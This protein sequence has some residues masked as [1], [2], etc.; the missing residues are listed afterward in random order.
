MKSSVSIYLEYIYICSSEHYKK[1]VILPD[2]RKIQSSH[3]VK[4]LYKGIKFIRFLRQ[5]KLLIVSNVFRILSA[6]K[7]FFHS[8]TCRFPL[9]KFGDEFYHVFFGYYDMSPFSNDNSR[10][11]A[12]RIPKEKLAASSKFPLEIGFY[13]LQAADL[14][15]KRIGETSTWCS[16]QGCRL[17]WYPSSSNRRILYNCI[18]EEAYGCAI[19]DIETGEVLRSIRRPVYTV[20]Q[21]GRWGL[22]L[23][24]S[25]LN[26]LRPGYGYSNFASCAGRFSSHSAKCQ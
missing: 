2:F 12:T 16:Q 11:L 3:S 10:L 17:Q 21:D 18:V 4:Q 26:R 20:S 24:F 9:I 6:F 15:Y 14:E 19:H 23:N 5:T 22:S 8:G 7:S 1:G 25:R 13:N